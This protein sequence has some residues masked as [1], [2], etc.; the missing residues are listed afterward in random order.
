MM[1]SGRIFRF[2]G[3]LNFV[4]KISMKIKK[5]RRLIRDHLHGRSDNRL[6][7]A[8]TVISVANDYMHD[9]LSAGRE[10]DAD[11][12]II[13]VP[14]DDDMKVALFAGRTILLGEGI[15]EY[16]LDYHDGVIEHADHCIEWLTDSAVDA[17]KKE[18]NFFAVL[19]D[20]ESDKWR[21]FR[22][23]KPMTLDEIKANMENTLH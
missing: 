9:A 6:A 15:K 14:A 3:Y 12:I 11:A 17:L 16:L 22:G 7:N 8:S 20:N 23:D 4:D 18:D 5:I 10:T 1:T 19:R 2:K 13:F 21:G